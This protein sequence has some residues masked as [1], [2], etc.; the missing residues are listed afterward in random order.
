[1]F[2]WELPPYNSG[3]LGVACYGLASA[4]AEKGL[5]V[6]FVLPSSRPYIP[7]PF[8]VR[9]ASNTPFDPALFK[10]ALGAYLSLE[11]YDRLSPAEK[12][13]LGQTLLAA[14]FR[15]GAAARQIALEENFDVIHAHDWLS[16]VA[17]L[18]A[19]KVS[20]KPL[21]VH[22]HL[23]AFEQSGGQ[24]ADPRVYAVERAGFE[25]GD[26]VV[27]VSELTKKVIVEKYGVPPEK[28]AVVYNGITLLPP[29]EH[30]PPKLKTVLG[31]SKLVLYVGRLTLHKGPDY[32]I[33]AAKLVLAKRPDVFFVMA[34]TGELEREL[35][36]LTARL[37]LGE[38][39]LFAG[40]VRSEAL[41]ELYQRA[42][43]FV[44]PSVYDPFGI[45][46]LEALSEKTPVIISKQAGASEVIAHALKVDFWDTRQLA[47]KILAV[48]EY[49]PLHD[50]LSA[51]GY[52]EVQRFP[53]S[54]A[55]AQLQ[56]IYAS[57]I[58]QQYGMAAS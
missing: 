33:R 6:T 38:R 24:G 42:D 51:Q 19:K 34:G 4:L 11:E 36:E 50:T 5:A 40:F 26:Q 57:V 45:A 9:F 44:M 49:P 21:V 25:G 13:A 58:K 46:A 29:G 23:T 28:I 31:N 18:T 53:W 56:T 55:A 16:F 47:A 8:K 54:R 43:V 35:V 37:G 20:G 41:A 3:G 27:A 52:N 32:L 17:G 12:A 22:A 48:L 14:V 39:V 7:G 2:G 1:M 10:T 30:L 15:F